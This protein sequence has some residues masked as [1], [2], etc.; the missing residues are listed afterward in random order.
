MFAGRSKRIATPPP[1][2]VVELHDRG[3][4]HRRTLQARVEEGHDAAVG[5]I[6]DGARDY[7][8]AVEVAAE[9]AQHA[10]Q[11][12]RGGAGVAT[13]GA[14]EGAAAGGAVDGRETRGR[15]PLRQRSRAHCSRGR[16]QGG[17]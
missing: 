17:P 7:G 13:E 15:S 10:A 12:H 8:R 2:A 6:A 3:A 16:G 14:S 9:G 5:G 4:A 1:A 11:D